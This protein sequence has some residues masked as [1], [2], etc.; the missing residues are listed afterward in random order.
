MTSTIRLNLKQRK[1][2]D[3]LTQIM[4]VMT[5][6][7]QR[8]RVYTRLRVE[9]RYWDSGRYRCN[10]QGRINLRERQRLRNVNER[11]DRLIENIWETDQR[12]AT[13]GSY[14][15]GN[16][17]RRL[18]TESIQRIEQAQTPMQ[19]LRNMAVEYANNI[20]RKGR[21]GIESTSTTYLTA[22]ERLEHFVQERELNIRT[23]D[24][25]NKKLFSEF[26]NYLYNYSYGRGK[27]A[28]CYTQTT[29]VNTLKVIKNLLHRAYDNELTANDYFQK[30]QT[31]LPYDVSEQ[32]Y[33]S[34]QEISHLSRVSVCNERERHVRD[35][36]CIACYTGLRIS[37]IRRIS[38]AHI[39]QGV[40]S[41]YQQKTKELV[42]IPILKEIA[43]LID[44]Y[45]RRG[46]PTIHSTTANYII[47]RLA[48][49]CSMDA[50]ITFKECRGGEV[51][52]VT[53]PKHSLI[54][55]HTA[56][57]SCITNL[58]KR[59]YSPNYIM[60]L[61]GHRSIQAFQRYMKASNHELLANFI[62][63]LREHKAI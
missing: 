57:R 54:S 51:R 3:K 38:E 40:L 39:H 9:P 28:R 18:V 49:R 11:I 33:L 20:N 2:L 17:L 30:V 48:A 6:N 24:D 43:P 50:P 63:Q 41:I 29:V 27:T 14:L 13:Q 34:E 58:Y 45:Q 35:M 8:V 22:L 61:S 21:R 37:D 25:F 36:F 1:N 7:R 60:T 5:I 59:G 12:L 32:V 23:F 47:K 62:H 19:S 44:Q 26:T 16:D 53:K 42:E 31:A 46:F 56:R 15:T 52:F 10:L 55:F 4:L